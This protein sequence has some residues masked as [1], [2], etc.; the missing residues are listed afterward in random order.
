MKVSD[1]LQIKG[2]KVK[3]VAPD[4]S[5]RELSVRLHAEQ[6]GAMLVSGDGRT[7]DGDRPVR[8]ESTTSDI[9]RVTL[10]PT[11]RHSALTVNEY[12][13]LLMRYD[14]AEVLRNPL[15]FVAEK[16][17]HALADPFAVPNKALGYAKYDMVRVLNRGLDALGLRG[18]FV[19][20]AMARTLAVPAARFFRMHR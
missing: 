4:T 3:T 12:E 14:L 16:S 6:I 8:Q 18:S 7:I 11:E 5:A 13:T 19:E 1:I 20:K 17:R 2:S 10:D 15:R 9:F